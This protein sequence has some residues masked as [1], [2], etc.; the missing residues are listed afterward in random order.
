MSPL[1]GEDLARYAPA[2]DVGYLG[3]G[4]QVVRKMTKNCL[5]LI[6]LEEAFADVVLQEQRNERNLANRPALRF[7]R[8]NM[9]RSA[10]SS[11][12]IVALAAPALLR[13][14]TKAEIRADVIATALSWP[15]NSL[16]WEID[17]SARMS[18]RRSLI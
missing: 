15:K 18:D 5:E 14:A 12:L 6:R 17:R 2:G 10:A 11:R 4:L 3:D 7:P 1:T 9:R 13:K 16:R 8:R